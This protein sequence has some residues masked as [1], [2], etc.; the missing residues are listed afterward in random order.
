MSE[1]VGW[2]V[3]DTS[4]GDYSDDTMMLPAGGAAT[5]GICHASGSVIPALIL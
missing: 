5:S 2:N 1:N 3:E 4:M